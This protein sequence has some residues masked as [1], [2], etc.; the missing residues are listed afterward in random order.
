MRAMPITQEFEPPAVTVGK[1]T[2]PHDTKTWSVVDTSTTRSGGRHGIISGTQQETRWRQTGG[3][4]RPSFDEAKQIVEQHNAWL[5]AATSIDLNLVKASVA[6]NKAEANETKALAFLRTQEAITREAEW[7][8]AG[9]IQA[10]QAQHNRAIIEELEQLGELTKDPELVKIIES[11]ISD[12]NAELAR[13]NANAPK[14][15]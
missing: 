6:L 2:I 7:V 13:V 14:R 15:N 1:F 11:R 10:A 12:L 8:L 9:L 3:D 4:G 5:E